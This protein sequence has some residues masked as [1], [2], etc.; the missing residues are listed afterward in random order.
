M[1]PAPAARERN[2]RSVMER[3]GSGLTS[4][5]NLAGPLFFKSQSSLVSDL[6]KEFNMV[7]GRLTFALAFGLIGIAFSMSALGHTVSQQQPPT[8]DGAARG[9]SLQQQGKTEEAVAS[10]RAAVKGNKNDLRAWHYLGLALE[11]KR[12]AKEARKAH[13]KAANLGDKLLAD[14]L[15]DA[16]SGEEI[17]R[18]L[19]PI[20]ENLAEAGESA[21]RYLQIAPKLSGR[22][23]LDS[24]LRAEFLLAFVEIAKA[25]PGTPA[26]LTGK[27]VSVKARVL[28]KPEP[29]YT[30]E[31]RSKNTTGTVVLRA[32]FAANGRVLGIRPVKGLPNGLTEQAIYVARQI[33][34]VP[35]IKDGRPVS[36]LVQLEYNFNL[37]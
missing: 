32:I 26:L 15:N 11:Q 24:Q 21:K 30:D 5:Q 9:I 1:S 3:N 19:T 18:R 14:L 22:K 33:K 7:T 29:Q 16:V 10:L 8:T 31:A 36:L 20:R 25:P 28:S 4:L 23:L 27:E 6:H 37:Y 35:A 34:F 17:S 13:H 12:D 2:I